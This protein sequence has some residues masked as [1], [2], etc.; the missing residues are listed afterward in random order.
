LPSP[1]ALPN[2]VYYLSV[3]GATEWGR[4]KLAQ[5]CPCPGK[6]GK[7]GCMM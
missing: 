1:K 3:K 5:S 7:K 4:L 2:G 6:K